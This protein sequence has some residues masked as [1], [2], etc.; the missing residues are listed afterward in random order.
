VPPSLV[1]VAIA[2]LAL[3]VGLIAVFDHGSKPKPK[4]RPTAR[5]TPVPHGA[6]A[7]QE[8]RNLSA[9]LSRYSR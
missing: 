6:S 3:T 5:V 9:W 8:A 7:A 2:V 1:L 4:L